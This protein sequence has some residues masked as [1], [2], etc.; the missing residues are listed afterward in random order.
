MKHFQGKLISGVKNSNYQLFHARIQDPVLALHH[1]DSTAEHTQPKRRRKKH[2]N[3]G[4]LTAFDVFNVRVPR[5]G[6][7]PKTR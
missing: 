5:L 2:G 6:L 3:E 7:E 4:L 1:S